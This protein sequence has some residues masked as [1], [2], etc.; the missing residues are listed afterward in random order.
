MAA[1]PVHVLHFQQREATT[2]G[3]TCSVE[4]IWTVS[5]NVSSSVVASTGT[6]CHPGTPS[7]QLVVD[8]AVFGLLLT[9]SIVL[10]WP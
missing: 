6:D 9:G 7:A 3:L 10:P 8:D 2:T 1:G 5:R 4:V